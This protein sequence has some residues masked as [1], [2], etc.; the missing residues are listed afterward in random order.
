MWYVHVYDFHR[1]LPN[2]LMVNKRIRSGCKVYNFDV[3][4]VKA[5]DVEKAQFVVN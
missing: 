1:I 2:V 5:L 3:F 4:G